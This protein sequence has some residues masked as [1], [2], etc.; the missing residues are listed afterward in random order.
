MD[1][2]WFRPPVRFWDSSV[3]SITSPALTTGMDALHRHYAD[4]VAEL[5]PGHVL[6]SM[7]LPIGDTLFATPAVAALRK[8]FPL[9][10]ITALVSRSNAGILEDNPAVDHLVVV[11]ELGPEHKVL[12]FARWLSELRAARYDLVINFSPVG[13]IVLRMAGLHRRPLQVVMP[14]LW[15]LIGGH[16]ESYRARH[17]T[18]HYLNAIEPIL[19][20]RPS[21]EE[22]QP[23]LYL[24]ARDRSRARKLLR[25]W[26]L[27][28]ANL[29]IAVHAGGE[30]F[31][32]RKRWGPERFASVA[33]QLVERF[34]AY[35]LLV[36]GKD[37][38]ALCQ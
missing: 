19:D 7:L 30:G 6:V 26:G 25:E 18:E 12:R 22:R 23:R 1:A 4:E 21:E 36:G 24:T 35:V 31:N 10:K 17:A 13:G 8:H 16:S 3:G 33:Q 38:E 15:W 37:D 32:G 20:R 27:S 5:D 34:D 11:D 2:T 28:P 9:A 14:L 29:L